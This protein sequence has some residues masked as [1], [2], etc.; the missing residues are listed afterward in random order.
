MPDQEILKEK[1]AEFPKTSGIYLWKDS[2]DCVLY[3]GKAKNLRARVRSYL[4]GT[5]TDPAKE[6]MIKKAAD[7]EYIETESEVDA[8]L[9]ENRLIKDIQ[10][11]YN[12]ALKDSK[13]YLF[14]AVEKGVDYPRVF[15]TR[16]KGLNVTYIGPFLDARGLRRS[17]RILQK[18]F[19]FR[20][21]TQEIGADDRKR[22][23]HR[24]CLLF[25]LRLCTGPCGLKIS[26]KN[27][28]ENIRNLKRFLNGK[29][30]R[31]L[32][33]LDKKMKAASKKQKYETAA[34]YRDQIKAIKS[35]AKYSPYGDFAERES[36]YLDPTSGLKELKKIFRLAKVPRLIDGLDIAT[37][38]GAE[39]VGSIVTFVD[40]QPFKDGYR[41]YRIKDVA[42]VDDYAMMRE[43]IGRRLRRILGGEEPMPDILL[44]DGG[45]GQLGAV[46]GVLDAMK[47]TGKK[48]PILLAL[49]K[50]QELIHSEGGDEAVRLPKRSDALR[51]LMYVRDEAHRFAQHY[52]H[53]LR[54]KKQRPK[55][56]QKK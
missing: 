11:K 39:S 4:S 19:R 5:A 15:P 16:E 7:V 26:K 1:V 23:Y 45:K 42:G 8:L 41:R 40:G 18:V 37:I 34:F 9:L 38:G 48:R 27:Y 36:F 43:V 28:H 14:L 56:V 21:C 10:P 50:R 49:A 53:L 29:K 52:H 55:R 12:V 47:V 22:R 46:A 3:I 44:I 20:S 35:L 24:P 54:K 30:S 6:E 51:V 2:R 32:K 25:N 17:I 31:L 33:D 13:S